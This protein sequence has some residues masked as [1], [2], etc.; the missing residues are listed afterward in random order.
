MGEARK[1]IMDYQN[2]ESVGIRVAAD[3]QRIWVCVN[4]ACVLRV[5]GIKILE[6]QDDREVA[7]QRDELLAAWM[8]CWRRAS[9]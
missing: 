7:Q 9:M 1:E 5:R 6:L 8:N 3:A 4:G 2:I